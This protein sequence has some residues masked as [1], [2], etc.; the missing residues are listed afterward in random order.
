MADGICRWGILGTA[1][2]ARKHWRGIH[3]ADNATI[4]AVASRT[5][6][7]AQRFI[8]SCS[9]AVPYPNSIAAVAPYEAL[10][11][12]DDVDAVYIPLPTAMRHKWVIRAAEKGKHVLAEKPAASDASQVLEMLEA[13]RENG[14]QY[15]D[16]VMFMHSA[17]LPMLRR[18]LD[19]PQNV[20]QLR[21]MTSQFSFSGDLEF[22]TRNIR[23]DSRLEPHGCLG[24][25]GW[26]CIRFFLWVMQASLPVSVRA[27]VLTAL[28]GE[29]SPAPVP[30]EFSADLYFADG[31]SASFYN[32]F[33]TENQQWVHLSGERG[34]LSISDFVLPYHGAEV[35]AY[36]N[37]DFFRIHNCDFHMEHH[38]RRFAV[39]E[40]SSAF[41]GAQEVRLIEEFSELVLSGQLSEVWPQWTLA[42]QIV[43][44]ACWQSAMND[45]RL[46]EIKT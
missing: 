42:T 22:R 21:R 3:T 24:D 36:V 2:I 11:D 25:L 17:R 12:R 34:S 19:D 5:T 39:S 28:H 14:V 8:D 6:E 32:S 20:G 9:A 37:N 27:N 40:Y 1:G 38:Q 23:V 7:G 13:C 29:G 33:I 16:G 35:A 18:L 44:D 41:A 4:T 31:V 45:G 26:Y 46:V 43:L 15:M 10:L 30:G